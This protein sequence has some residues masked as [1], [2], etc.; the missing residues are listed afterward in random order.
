[1]CPTRSSSAVA[2]ES[3]AGG[4]RPS[5]RLSTVGARRP[6]ARRDRRRPPYG[7]CPS[8]SPAIGVDLSSGGVGGHGGLWRRS[9]RW[10]LGG[11][12]LGRWP[13]ASARIVDGHG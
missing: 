12:A 4:G 5:R 3:K 10:P 6:E 9:A 13:P 11:I 2:A 8:G 7:A 1:M